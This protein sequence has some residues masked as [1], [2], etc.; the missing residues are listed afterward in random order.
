[1]NQGLFRQ[2][3]KE[4][5][6]SQEKFITFDVVDV[7]KNY[8]SLSVADRDALRA[9]WLYFLSDQVRAKVF[10]TLTVRNESN[11]RYP[12]Q[13]LRTL[14]RMIKAMNKD[15]CGNHANR[16]NPFLYCSFVGGIEYTTNQIIHIHMVFDR[17][18]NFAF[19]HRW[20]GKVAGFAFIKEVHDVHGSFEYL[21]KYFSKGGSLFFHIKK[22]EYKLPSFIPM[23]F[24]DHI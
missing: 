11:I 24:S 21:T 5:F 2:D 12:E 15:F 16:L 14:V 23:W 20:W 13:I 8:N 3:T 1:M 19:I 22:D 7:D 17:P 10:V 9:S 18:V 6:M 4:W